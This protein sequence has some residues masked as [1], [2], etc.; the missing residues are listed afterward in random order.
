MLV[1]LVLNCG[2]ATVLELVDLIHTQLLIVVKLEDLDVL[3]V[4]DSL[5]GSLLLSV[6][7]LFTMLHV[8]RA[9]S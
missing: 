5:E 9:Q 4:W 8:A 1:L 3:L 2:W 6:L 7:D